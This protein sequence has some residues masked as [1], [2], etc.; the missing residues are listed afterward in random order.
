MGNQCQCAE[1][2]EEEKQISVIIKPSE[3]T[4]GLN[5]AEL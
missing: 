4:N 2:I 1:S 3:N 5:D